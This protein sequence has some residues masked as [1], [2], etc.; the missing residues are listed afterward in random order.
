MPYISVDVDVD[1]QDFDSEDLVDEL[2]SRGYM[3]V[4]KN[5][6]HSTNSDTHELVQQ[7]YQKRRTGQDFAGDLDLLIFN[8][9]GR[10]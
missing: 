9:I 8:M 7:I 1:V 4:F 6:E 5:A 3:M 2:E 10:M